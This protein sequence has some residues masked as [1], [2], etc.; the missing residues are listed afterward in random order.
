M[1]THDSPSFCPQPILLILSNGSRTRFF[2]LFGVIHCL[3]GLKPRK[4]RIYDHLYYSTYSFKIF[5]EIY[6]MTAFE[7]ELGVKEG[8]KNKNG[9]TLHTSMKWE[10][11][12]NIGRMPVKNGAQSPHRYG[13]VVCES[14]CKVKGCWF[15]SQ[16]GHMPGL[17]VIGAQ[18]NIN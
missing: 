15:D 17:Q 6:Y 4:S 16:S 5:T 13:S 8:G 9:P 11:T 1:S 18:R 7:L 3:K 14:P 10:R 12:E 2:K